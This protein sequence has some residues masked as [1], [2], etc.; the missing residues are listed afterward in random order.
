[1]RCQYIYVHFYCIAHNFTYLLEFLL[2]NIICRTRAFARLRIVK[3]FK[4]F[5]YLPTKYN[6][7]KSIK[8][9]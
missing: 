3:K 2:D 6:K 1:M 9:S 7:F 5:L 8:K 4:T